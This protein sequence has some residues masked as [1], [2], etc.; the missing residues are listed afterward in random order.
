M[1]IRVL[2][3]KHEKNDEIHPLLHGAD[4]VLGDRELGSGATIA[5]LL[6]RLL[7]GVPGDG[8]SGSYGR[9]LSRV[10]VTGHACT[11]CG[12]VHLHRGAVTAA[13]ELDEA[14]PELW[15]HHVNIKNE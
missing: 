3:L 4:F 14:L 1:A 8:N 12:L 15:T 5:L 10:G 2:Q 6:V 7:Q 13:K 11:L 9:H